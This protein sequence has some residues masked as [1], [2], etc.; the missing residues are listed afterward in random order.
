MIQQT[1]QDSNPEIARRYTLSLVASEQA[2][3]DANATE[4]EVIVPSSDYPHGIVQ[5][6]TPLSRRTQEG[7]GVLTIPVQRNAGPSGEIR[8]NYSVNSLSAIEG[9][10]YI[11]TESC[12]L[13]L[14]AS[15]NDMISLCIIVL[16]SFHYSTQHGGW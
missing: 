4:V 11:S 8:V 1:L 3:L 5:F 15:I 16:F 10:D 6:Q 2:P 14:V 9:S 12:E 13:Y 7:S